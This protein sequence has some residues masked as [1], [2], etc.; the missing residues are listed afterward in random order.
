MAGGGEDDVGGVA[1]A[2]FEIAAA[3]VTFGLQV[4]GDGLDGGAAPQFAPDDTEDAALL[5]R[6]EDVA[7]ILRVVAA[8]A[9][10]DIGALD[11]TAGA[12]DDLPSM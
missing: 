3:E 7:G 9:L 5:A 6:H 10:V 12:V 2:A 8:V 11:R 4:A 1:G